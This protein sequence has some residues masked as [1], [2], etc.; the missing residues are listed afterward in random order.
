MLCT[1]G[2]FTRRYL[3]SLRSSPVCANMKPEPETS[4]GK[5]AVA[6]SRCAPELKRALRS[7]S[8]GL[9]W[10]MRS[11]LSLTKSSSHFPLYIAGRGAFVGA[12]CCHFNSPPPALAPTDR[13]GI[14]ASAAIGMVACGSGGRR[15]I[16]AVAAAVTGRR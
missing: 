7:R 9:G 5:A 12:P 15:C 8:D 3:F 6:A 13:S 10:M 2:I 1:V 14:P 4:C 16:R 11:P